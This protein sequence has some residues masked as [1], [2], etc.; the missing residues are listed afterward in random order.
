MVPCEGLGGDVFSASVPTIGGGWF[1][2]QTNSGGGRSKEV[3]WAGRRCGP[4]WAEISW[5]GTQGT[6]AAPPMEPRHASLGKNTFFGGSGGENTQ[7]LATGIHV[8]TW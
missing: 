6:A 5:T 4:S 2:L 7:E 3:V 1:L 8:D